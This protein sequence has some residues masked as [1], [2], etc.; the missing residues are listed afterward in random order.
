MGNT[1]SNNKG[2]KRLCYCTC[3]ILLL[4]FPMFCMGWSEFSALSLCCSSIHSQI[5]HL[6]FLVTPSFGRWQERTLSVGPVGCLCEV[7]SS[8]NSNNV[9]FCVY[10]QFQVG[11]RIGWSAIVQSMNA[12]WK[13][14]HKRPRAWYHSPGKHLAPHLSGQIVGIHC[15]KLTVLSSTLVEVAHIHPS[16]W[17]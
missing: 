10:L 1:W 11:D 4:L 13:S 17:Q 12:P 15:S 5:T 14:A 2:V 7:I 6:S 8:P 9:H 3:T 16:H